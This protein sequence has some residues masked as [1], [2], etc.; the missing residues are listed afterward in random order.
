LEL[1]VRTVSGKTVRDM[2]VSNIGRG[3]ALNC[4]YVR[5]SRGDRREFARTGVFNLAAGHVIQ[6]PAQEFDD[7]DQRLFASEGQPR[8]ALLCQDQFGNTFR[9]TPGLARPDVFSRSESGQPV[10]GTP[11]W[12]MAFMQVIAYREPEPEP[13]PGPSFLQSVHVTGNNSD[14]QTTVVWE[15]VPATDLMP[16]D[17]EVDNIEESMRAL[18]PKARRASAEIARW[19]YPPDGSVNEQWWARAYPGPCVS[20]TTLLRLNAR[21]SA[22]GQGLVAD[23]PLV[24]L[25]TLWQVT[26]ITSRRLAQALNVR[27]MRLG[28][29]LVM[30][31][32]YDKPRLQDVD[33]GPL[34]KPVQ[35]AS[36]GYYV[37]HFS[38]TSMP[39]DTS[40]WPKEFL[41]SCVREVLRRFGYRAIDPVIANLP[42]ERPLSD[43]R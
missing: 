38:G 35:T 16:S 8:E 27:R 43:P 6:V 12:A 19:A 14:C 39:F 10:S 5:D 41:E 33:F 37:G 15:A 1:A 2:H 30:S 25:A 34:D 29:T 13:Q 21:A 28:L 36:P 26:V 40:E 7:L 18:E 31:G 32:A 17:S 42:F 4:M 11:P 20:I 9:F 23:L 24:D 3:P 22:S